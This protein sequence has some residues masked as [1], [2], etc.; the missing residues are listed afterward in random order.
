MNKQ[1]EHIHGYANIDGLIPGIRGQR[2]FPTAAFR[3]SDP[4]V[5]LDHI[6]PETVGKAY[7]LD[8]SEH[9]H[10]HRGFETL[11]FM[12]EGIMDHKDSLGNEV[13]LNSGS[14]Q[15][16]NAGSG[17]IHGGNM[18]ADPKT[19]RFHELQLWINNPAAEKMSQPDI[20]NVSDDDIPRIETE[21]LYLR[22]ISG[23]L[24]G[25]QGPIQ[26]KA[27]TQIA[28][29][30]STDAAELSIQGFARNHTTMLYVLEGE[31]MV[32]EQ[33]LRTFQLATLTS[34]GD[35]IHISSAG[36]SQL[37]LLSG[38]PLKETVVLGGPFVM[39]SREEIR[40]AH[41]DYQMGLFGTIN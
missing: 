36:A 40:Q 23:H 25:I 37:L 12:F 38:K 17:I 21:G 2:A 41:K 24:N 6:G 33:Q 18:G 14:V 16:M 31:V 26:T 28:H 35:A 9:A 29:M 32:N 30:V 8:G 11:T 27:H 39:N 19:G 7:F 10:P 1:I 3:E 13:R 15:R 5:M 34:E 22:V 4:F 20:H